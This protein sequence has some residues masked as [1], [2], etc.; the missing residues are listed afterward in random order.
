[1]EVS[2]LPGDATIA[3]FAMLAYI[4]VVN[5]ET[6]GQAIK[7]LRTEAGY[8]LRGFAEMVGISAAYLSDIEHDRRNPTEENLRKIAAKLSQRVAVT[9]EELRALSA[10]LETDLQ[11]LVQ[12]TPEVGQLLREV[13]ETGRPVRDVLRELQE[14]LRNTHP[15]SDEE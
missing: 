3:V 13:K 1:M 11:Q 7:R 14:H 2:W 12:Q 10:R 9:Y 6:L 15:E 5:T 8:T 4:A